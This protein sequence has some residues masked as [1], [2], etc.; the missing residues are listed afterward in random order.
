MTEGKSAM[1]NE[2]LQTEGRQSKDGRSSR[3]D[4]AVSV[5]GLEAA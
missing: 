3:L 2:P 4:E 5:Q 1:S